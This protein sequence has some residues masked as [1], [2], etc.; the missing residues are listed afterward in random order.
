MAIAGDA[1][2]IVNITAPMSLP[3][4][5]ISFKGLGFRD[6]AYTYLMPHGMPSHV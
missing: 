1:V 3:A 2:A 6:A 5:G 4:T